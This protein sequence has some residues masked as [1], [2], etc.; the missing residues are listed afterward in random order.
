MAESNMT[1]SECIKKSASVAEVLIAIRDKNLYPAQYATFEDYV[2]DRW[3]EEY[4]K[5]D[6]NFWTSQQPIR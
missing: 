1:E 4:L 2:R 6:L 5:T 3:G